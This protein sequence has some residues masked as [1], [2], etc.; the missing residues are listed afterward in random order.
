MKKKFITALLCA[1]MTASM[2][3]GCGNSGGGND[4]KADSNQG[5]DANA[6][7]DANADAGDDADADADAGDDAAGAS[8]DENTLTVWCWDPKFNIY[9]MEEAGKVYQADHPE[10][11]VNVVETPW[12]DVQ[13]KLT[14]AATGGAMDT[15][16]DI[17]L[18]QDNAFQKNV[19]SFPEAFTD[20]TDSGIDFTQF[21]EAKTAYSVVDGKNYGVPFDNGAVVACYRTDILQEA[22]F[23]LDDF[24]DITWDEYLEKGK[25][26]LEKTGKPLLSC[27]STESDVIMMMLQSCGASLFDD[28]GKPAMVGNESLKKVMETYQQLVETGVCKLV[29]SWDEY[30]QTLTTETVAGTINGCWIM[31]SIQ[32]AEDQSGKWGLTN[33]PSLVGV[34]GATNYSNNGGSSWA[35]TSNCKNVELAKDF[36]KSTFAGSVE[37]Y[38]TILP[39]SGALATY[40]PAGDS[41]V[42]AE[43]SEFYG[44]DAV[45]KKIT[46]YASK[47]PS[48]NTG[49]YYYEGRDA[50]AT[51]IQNVVG[52]SDIDAE[53]EIAQS[54]VEG[55]MDQ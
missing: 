52:G 12:D 23:T 47:C 10:F 44:G 29:N 49:V 20:L 16:P 38:E 19:I 33:M 2:L 14:T 21:G 6:G 48:N 41:A 15:L 30:V 53:L 45:F 26:V 42:Y 24:T 31:A 11:N 36:L 13:K 1:A 32:S 18:V 40:L 55:L 27:Q 4:Q 9:A 5:E 39:S 37:L 51:A 8:G 43:P 46:E 25:V 7:D 54:T 28:E 22:G 17:M 35:I 34:E 3:A 50:I